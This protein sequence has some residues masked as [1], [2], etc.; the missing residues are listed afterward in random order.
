MKVKKVNFGQSLNEDSNITKEYKSKEEPNKNQD[1]EMNYED[2]GFYDDNDSL[3]YD[4]PKTTDVN[5]NTHQNKADYFNRYRKGNRKDILQNSSRYGIDRESSRPNYDSYTPN[6]DKPYVDNGD[7]FER[8]LENVLGKKGH[9]RAYKDSNTYKVCKGGLKVARGSY[10]VVKVVGKAGVSTAK[11]TKLLSKFGVEK[12]KSEYKSMNTSA[13]KSNKP[14]KIK[15]AVDKINN[16]TKAQL[17]VL[18]FL[19]VV[20]LIM[21]VKV[22]L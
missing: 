13:T 9:V 10:K 7:H 14:S 11:V 15:T 22:L 3:Y 18:G 19:C 8:K 16:S 2:Y 12:L 21:F 4:T 20:V 6:N 17:G 5:Y 1:K